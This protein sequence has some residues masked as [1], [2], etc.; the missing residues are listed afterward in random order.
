MGSQSNQQVTAH[1]EA[2]DVVV[3]GGG[4][5]GLAASVQLARSGFRVTCFEPA[6][7]FEHIVGESLDWSAPDLFKELELRMD[8]LI[9][10]EVATYKRHVI[11]KLPDDSATEYVP[12]AWLSR[13]PLNIELRTMHVDRVRLHQELTRIASK[14]G[15]L[16]VHDRVSGVDRNGRFITGVRTGLGRWFTAKWFIDASGAAA[17]MF[18]REFRLPAVEYGPKKVA[19]WTYFD[20]SDW[21][22]GTTLFATAVQREYMSW[23]WEIPIRPGT[24]SVGCVS[25]GAEV[26]Q[27]RGRALSVKEIF[28]RQLLMFDRFRELLRESDVPSI[29]VTAFTCRVFKKVCGPNWIIIGEAA[30]LPDPITGNG[31]TAALRHAAEASRLICRFRSNGRISAWAQAAYSLRVLHMGKFFN[32][33]I[34]KLA[35]DWPIRDRIG[36]LTA[37]D[38]Y[39][40]PAW[41][42]NQ[43]Y[44]RIRPV[45]MF[46]TALFCLFLGSLRGIAWIFYHLCR[47]FSS[48]PR[49]LTAHES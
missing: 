3:I 43:I 9:R 20:V 30:S 1:E 5:S 40:I 12:S 34:E 37:G 14:S 24:I 21:S 10:N 46:S 18:G 23:I 19:M 49:M 38:A 47:V 42:I 48:P 27:L 11:L 4:L 2:T 26:K 44:S 28:T 32:S 15:V 45:G 8:D 33:L 39:T 6:T 29:E 41:S 13:P 25:T 31:V 35:Y 7:D 16:M 36:L 22:E 17:S